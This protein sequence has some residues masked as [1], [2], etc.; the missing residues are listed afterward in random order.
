MLMII[1]SPIFAS[2][3]NLSSDEMAEQK[4]IALAMQQ[5]FEIE[6]KGDFVVAFQSDEQELQYQKFKKI[7]KSA[8]N[9]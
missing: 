4:G 3:Q 9:M 7:M 1:A 8:K 6:S 2:Q 5:R